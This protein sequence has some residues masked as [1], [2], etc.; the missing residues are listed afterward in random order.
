MNTDSRETPFE[1]L[2]VFRHAKELAVTVYRVT[3]TES[4]SRDYGLK[5]QLRRACVSIFSNIAEGFERGSNTEFIQFLYISKGSCGELRAQLTFAYVLKYLELQTFQD[6]F[7]S[8]R[9]LSIMIAK[10]IGY[11]KQ[12]RYR[13]TKYKSTRS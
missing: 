1:N 7:N 3:S 11:L 6:L 9:V 10:F 12:S 5:D 4:F 2:R 8:C 13:G